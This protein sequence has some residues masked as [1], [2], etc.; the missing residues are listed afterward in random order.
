[1]VLVR[2][3]TAR[4]STTLSAHLPVS[5]WTT[6]SFPLIFFFFLSPYFFFPS[7]RSPCTMIFSIYPREFH[8]EFIGELRTVVIP[9]WNSLRERGRRE[10]SEIHP[11]IS[12]CIGSPKMIV[13]C[14][15]RMKKR[16][17]LSRAIYRSSVLSLNST[18][19]CH[20]Y[21]FHILYFALQFL[22]PEIDNSTRSD[23]E[24]QCSIRPYLYTYIWMS[25]TNLSNW[26]VLNINYL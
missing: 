23:F 22:K 26:S 15:S 16:K 20:L 24:I 1:M 9:K 7:K 17:L 4:V 21:Y 12:N 25:L 8:G 2:E 13:F 11:S 6:R 19:D 3:E 10:S 14:R 5:L 18:E